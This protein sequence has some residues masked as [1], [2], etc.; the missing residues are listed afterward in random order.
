[1]ILKN[2]CDQIVRRPSMFWCAQW[3][4]L[5]FYTS[6]HVYRVCPRCSGRQK[7]ANVVGADQVP[8]NTASD[9]YFSIWNIP[10]SNVDA[11]TGSEWFDWRY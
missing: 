5:S 4:M 7:Y 10:S 11:S 9:T 6:T 3:L 1:M 8:K 2:T